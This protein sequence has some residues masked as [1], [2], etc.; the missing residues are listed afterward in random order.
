MIDGNTVRESGIDQV[1]FGRLATEEAGGYADSKFSEYVIARGS[2][3]P[4]QLGWYRGISTSQSR[5]V[6]RGTFDILHRSYEAT[7]RK[8]DR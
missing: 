5:R 1:T 6:L 3:S 2:S 8:D 7:K 4:A